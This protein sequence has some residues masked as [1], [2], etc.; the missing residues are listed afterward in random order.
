MSR[1]TLQSA[2][3]KTSR[4][5]VRQGFR[6]MHLLWHGGEPLL[7]GLEFYK[8]AIQILTQFSSDL[9]C[10]IFI[11][12]NGLLLDHD[13][14]AFF[15]DH[16]FQI[17]VSLDGPPDLHDSMRVGPNGQGSHTKVMEKLALLAE[18]GVQVG[19]N[20]VVS[21]RALVRRRASIVISK[22]W[23]NPAALTP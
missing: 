5:A 23:D 15:R 6:E 4:Y 3:V 1:Q 11:Q 8:T 7:A 9:I 10:R 21:P 12:T 22:A 2:L 16:E 13:Y 18:H 14:C 17:G 19:T 20:A